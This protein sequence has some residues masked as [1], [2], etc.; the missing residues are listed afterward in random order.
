MRARYA[1]REED[2]A[3]D[4]SYLSGSPSG[5]SSDSCIHAGTFVKEKVLR[6]L[7]QQQQFV[8]SDMLSIAEVEVTKLAS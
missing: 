3:S 2:L 8:F 1:G 6:A 7:L 5:Q 4:M